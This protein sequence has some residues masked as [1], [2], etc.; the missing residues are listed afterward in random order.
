[1]THLLEE[2]PIERRSLR[3]SAGGETGVP[4]TRILEPWAAVV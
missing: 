2:L 4:K 1:M 3:H